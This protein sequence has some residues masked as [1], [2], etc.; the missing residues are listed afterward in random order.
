MFAIDCFRNCHRERY[1]DV[2]TNRGR[3]EIAQSKRPEVHPFQ[4]RDFTG[5]VS[6]SI[7]VNGL[8]TFGDSGLDGLP[9]F[10]WMSLAICRSSFSP[11]DVSDAVPVA[12]ACIQATESLKQTA[13]ANARRNVVT[14][15]IIRFIVR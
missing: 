6:D 7:W 10:A 3:F 13:M 1:D 4:E 14:R 11:S 9:F 2:V 15:L 5:A 8:K 12:W